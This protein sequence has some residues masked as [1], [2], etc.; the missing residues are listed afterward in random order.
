MVNMLT[1]EELRDSVLPLPTR[2]ERYRRVLMLGTTGAGKTTVV[3]QL[4]GTNPR[5]E[6]FPSTSTAKT[7]VAD[8]EIVPRDEPFFRAAVTFM[9]RVEVEDHLLDNVVA[10]AQ[11]VY[12][13]ADDNAVYLKLLDHEGQRFRLSYLLGRPVVD[14][15]D[16]IIDD[17]IDD[18][19]I[20]DELAS[21]VGITGDETMEA[22]LAE[23]AGLVDV[24][25]AG[26][27]EVV[28]RAAAKVRTLVRSILLRLSPAETDQENE[29]ALYEALQDAVAES[30][31]TEEIIAMLVREVT[32]R[33]SAL[34][35]G[36]LTWDE[37]GWPLIWTQTSTD[38]VRF[39]AELST[40]YG[41]S[42]TGFG[43]L[44]TPVV[45]G[46][47]VS[48]PFV[49]TWSDRPLRLV[50]VDSE[51][52]GHTP[53][54]ISSLSSSLVRKVSHS[55]SVLVVDNAQQPMQAGPLAAL[56]QI[57]ESGSV[58]KLHL[59]FTHLDGV[60]GP[61]LTTYSTRTGHVRESVDNALSSIESA[62]GAAA[63]RAL[64]RRLSTSVYFA[65]RLDRILNS[66]DTFGRKG[67]AEFL[68]LQGEL[69]GEDPVR[70]HGD[71]EI[72][73]ARKGVVIAV[74]KATARFQE[75][76]LIRL[77]V[78]KPRPGVDLRGEHWARVKALNRRIVGRTDFE[79]RDLKPVGDF[80]RALQSVLYG[81]LQNPVRW[82]GQSVSEE[83]RSEVIDTIAVA[84]TEKVVALA[85]KQIILDRM[86]A[87][88]LGWAQTGKG[89]AA[90]RADILAE[91]V[92]KRG[93]PIP[94]A[95]MSSEATELVNAV[96]RILEEVHASH[97][98]VLD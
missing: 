59:L 25:V 63:A 53:S 44:V 31:I 1:F 23:G 26:S 34:S 87:W 3:R 74:E 85:E 97:N 30:A 58:G 33:F 10:A 98:L 83:E 16:D 93:A 36:D 90:R 38:R 56:T 79:Y 22:S 72:V 27:R 66:K 70:D 32:S 42:A 52:L 14:D 12:E 24:D 4:L 2:E 39:L 73:V 77:G 69:E 15:D 91:D 81:M 46:I 8:T 88:D 19:I 89:S 41:N 57:V 96:E 18:D 67:A 68:R 7:T 51:G 35:F 86:D 5:T 84:L 13:G 49:P 21:S 11:A 60:K 29:D 17:L 48:G 82:Q 40:F 20:E 71:A 94:T 9:P 64:R 62:A 55:D 78:E 76:W 45:N 50:I 47:R 80:R 37:E 75:E 95:D 6:R 92:I 54:S 28:E 61:N 65:G 43:R